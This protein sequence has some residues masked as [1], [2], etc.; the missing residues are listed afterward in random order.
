MKPTVL[1]VSTGSEAGTKTPIAQK[2]PHS[3]P[4]RN[5]KRYY[6]IILPNP[7]FFSLNYAILICINFI[8][9]EQISLSFI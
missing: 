1:Q 2:V 9:E 6:T 7:S 3:S 8:D 4:G 5:L